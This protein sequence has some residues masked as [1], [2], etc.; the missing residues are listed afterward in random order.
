MC[1]WVC[2]CACVVVGVCAGVWLW[3]S[4]WSVGAWARMCVGVGAVFFFF[5]KNVFVFLTFF[6]SVK[7]LRSLKRFKSKLPKTPGGVLGF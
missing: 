6:K 1:G 2:A 5:K 7:S 4:A 3:V